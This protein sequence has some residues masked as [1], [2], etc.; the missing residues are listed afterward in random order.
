MQRVGAS[1]LPA[2]LHKLS[3]HNTNSSSTTPCCPPCRS[4]VKEVAGAAPAPAQGALH[5]SSALPPLL[6]CTGN[7]SVRN[8][9][10]FHELASFGD[11]D[12][13]R[14]LGVHH[15]YPPVSR[16]SALLP[17]PSGRSSLTA[18]APARH[19]RKWFTTP[20]HWRMVRFS[21]KP[22]SPWI[23]PTPPMCC[24]ATH[25]STLSQA[26]YAQPSRVPACS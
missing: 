20:L 19:P 22:G 5:G 14:F 6:L 25:G 23:K 2:N 9:S 3:E 8:V 1:A 16:P 10:S 17:L 26:G 24:C 13:W 7:N 4:K 21:G 18:S 12:G 11:L 15:A